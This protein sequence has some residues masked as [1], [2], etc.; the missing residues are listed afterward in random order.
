[1]PVPFPEPTTPVPS[2]AEVL[3]GYLDFFRSGVG[4]KLAA[5]TTH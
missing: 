2:R 1:M 5:L 3:L 4:A